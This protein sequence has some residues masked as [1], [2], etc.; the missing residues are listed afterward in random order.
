MD[1]AERWQDNEA[2]KAYIEAMNKFR[3][4]CPV[5]ER[6][7]KAH[8]SNY[9]GL[10]ETLDEI[11]D[12][13]SECGLSHTWKTKQEDGM[14]SVTCCV[15]HIKGHQECTSLSAPNDTS[16]SKNAIQAMGSTVSY[17]QR[18]TLF[19]ILGIASKEMDNDGG[20]PVEYI[21][22][23]MANLLDSKIE[24]NELDRVKFNSWL[25]R[26][27]KVDSLDKVSMKAY[28]RVDDAIK[29]AIKAKDKK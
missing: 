15:T 10:A 22:E 6:T 1:L 4:E 3:A 20:A 28:K 24:E 25:K 11:K 13:L 17:L 21:T 9:A 26:D 16:G 12:L 8:N 7:K 2:K 27:L 14:T 18:Y 23:E 29:R 5:I 19:S